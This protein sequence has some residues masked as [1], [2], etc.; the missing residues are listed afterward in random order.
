[1]VKFLN[2]FLLICALFPVYTTSWAATTLND[3]PLQEAGQECDLAAPA[4]LTI[5]ET[6]T[7]YITIAWTAVPNAYAYEV[8]V[9]EWDE[10]LGQWRLIIQDSTFG[11]HYTATGLKYATTYRFEVAAKCNSRDVS[12]NYSVIIGDTIII[13]LVD[14][15]RSEL[16][17]ESMIREE[18]PQNCL[19]IQPFTGEESACFWFDLGKTANGMTFYSRYQAWVVKS[20]NGPDDS[21]VK[22]YKIPAE[23]S[24][25]SSWESDPRNQDHFAPPCF[26]K[27]VHIFD[28]ELKAFLV[29]ASVEQGQTNICFLVLAAGYNVRCLVPGEYPPG[30]GDTGGRSDTPADAGSKSGIGVSNPFTDFLRIKSPL[31]QPDMPVLIQLF[32]ANG[33]LVLDEK[34]PAVQEYN[35]PTHHLAPGFYVLKVRANQNTQTLKVVK[36]H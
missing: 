34:M 18:C 22:I 12:R 7:T 15:G 36:V 26:A 20:G 24:S 23:S 17:N 8:R 27:E 10:G 21:V 1:M 11:T 3:P 19:V 6:G 16:P 9:K 14:M 33:R 28:Q 13:D 32:D 31:T 25:F 4:S 29:T 2:S 35:L 30:G 5:V